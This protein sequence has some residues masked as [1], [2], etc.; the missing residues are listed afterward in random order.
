ML[1][2]RSP[3][4]Q[5]S[6]PEHPRLMVSPGP[7]SPALGPALQVCTLEGSIHLGGQPFSIGLYS[8]G[9]NPSIIVRHSSLASQPTPLPNLLLPS[10][11]SISD[12]HILICS[13]KQKEWARTWFCIQLSERPTDHL[14]DR[15][16]QLT[17][18]PHG[19][20]ETDLSRSDLPENH[21]SREVCLFMQMS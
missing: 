17:D 7:P 8:R 16:S 10:S 3:R 20:R 14:P 11:N 4:Q 13:T 21:T 19:S 18:T 1:R 2:T 5:E 9:V 15:E 12:F 6:P